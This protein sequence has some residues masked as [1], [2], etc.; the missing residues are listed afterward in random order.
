MLVK[1]LREAAP[2]QRQQQPPKVTLS[3]PHQ[4][5]APAGQPPPAAPAAQPQAPDQSQVVNQATEAI[6]QI[7]MPLVAQA[8]Q[9]G[10]QKIILPGVQAAL[11]GQKQPAPVNNAQPKPMPEA[12][13]IA[14]QSGKKPP[15]T[16]AAQKAGLKNPVG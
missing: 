16:A 1:V 12:D 3:G 7:I 6:K 2:V 14:A 9:D 5:P 11:K 8:I 15:P 10:F 13:Q 4:A